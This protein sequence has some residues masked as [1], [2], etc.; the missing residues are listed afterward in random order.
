[1]VGLQ[2]TRRVTAKRHF[3]WL[4]QY[5][6]Q[7]KLFNEIAKQSGAKTPSVFEAVRG[8]AERVIGPGWKGWLRRAS[9]G[10]PRNP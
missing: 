3:D 2:P 9:R 10:R 1:V 8:A 4:V 7:G 5:Q 6:V